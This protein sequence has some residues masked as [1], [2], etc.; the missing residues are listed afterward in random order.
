[1]ATL[2]FLTKYTVIDE[3]PEV[4][5]TGLLKENSGPYEAKPEILYAALLTIIIYDLPWRW[6]SRPD[7]PIDAYKN[8]LD[9]FSFYALQL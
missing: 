5:S 7:P 8:P 6:L 1:M 3:M 9:V 4:S 2:T